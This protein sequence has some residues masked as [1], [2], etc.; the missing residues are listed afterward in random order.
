[1]R[2]F[3][4]LILGL[5]GS[6]SF[7]H[8]DVLP[9]PDMIAVF[10]QQDQDTAA[11]QVLLKKG[12]LEEFYHHAGMLVEGIDELKGEELQIPD[13]KKLFWVYY[14]VVLA[15]LYQ[16]DYDEKTE[17]RFEEGTD[18]ETKKD[19]LRGMESLSWNI[20]KIADK[21][22]IKK[23]D[24][25]K[26]LVHYSS[27]IVKTY[28]QAYDRDLETKHQ[29]MVD[30][31]Q[32]KEDEWTAKEDVD[33]TLLNLLNDRRINFDNKI[34]LHENRND[35]IKGNLDDFI[36]PEWLNILL[37]CYPG[38]AATL[39]RYLS[40]GGYEDKEV[41]GLLNRTLGRTKETECLYKGFGKKA[42]RSS[43]EEVQKN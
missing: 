21:H 5:F 33:D 22:H 17:C 26:L 13:L 15:P 41:P 29:K 38:Q 27:V 35:E 6:L 28:R 31:Y 12:N 23:E 37:R 43:G 34:I 16:I 10:G 24:L 14:Y 2:T 4:Y 9:K 32:K 18:Y 20:K 42:R 36:E 8:A 11:L 25:S 1:M 30:E 40:M 19:M 7:A 3:F 39:K